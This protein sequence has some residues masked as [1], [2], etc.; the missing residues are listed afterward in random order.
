MS[1]GRIAF[2]I[3]SSAV[4]LLI[5]WTGYER[6]KDKQRLEAEREWQSFKAEVLRDVR[7]PQE[8]DGKVSMF[9]VWR[10]LRFYEAQNG[11]YPTSTEGLPEL[12]LMPEGVTYRQLQGGQDYEL[13]YFPA[14]GHQRCVN[15]VDVFYPFEE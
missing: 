13:C 6:T 3:V 12:T 5:V 7:Y 8:N 2:V 14:P 10:S 9:D 15:K 1:N 4:I 11:R